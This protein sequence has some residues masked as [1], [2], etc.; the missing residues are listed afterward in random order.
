MNGGRR[1]HRGAVK[2]ILAWYLLAALAPPP[3]AADWEPA[4]LPLTGG[5]GTIAAFP[6]SA[7][8]IRRTL[9][10]AHAAHDAAR[11]RT[12]LDALARLGYAPSEETIRLL[13]PYLSARA[14]AGLARRFAANRAPIARSR[15][16]AEV[17]AGRRLI[18][19]IAFD[20]RSGRLFAGSV[21]GREL[22]VLDEGAW[23]AVPGVDGGSLFGMA[24]DA[25]RRLLWIASGSLDRTPHPETAFRGLIAVDLDDLRVRRRV[26]LAASPGDVTVG[27]DGAV[28]ASDGEG[29]AVF[30]LRPGEDSASL[31]VPA[32]RLRSA[33]GLAVAPDGR[34]L[35]VADYLFGIGIVDLASG[36]VRRLAARRPAM[37]DGIDGLLFHR[38]VLIAIQNGVAPHRIVRLRL[39]RAGGTVTAVDPLER[40]NPAWGEPTLGTIAGNELLYVADGQWERYAAGPIETG[41][42]RPTPIRAL[43]LPGTSVEPG[44]HRSRGARIG[45][46][47]EGQR[48]RRVERAGEGGAGGRLVLSAGPRG[49]GFASHRTT[50]LTGSGADHRVIRVRHECIMS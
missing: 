38:G 23:R 25:P 32:G 30:R 39:D 21:V 19:G 33:Q 31:L 37:L 7:S 41:A 8:A 3:G 46:G 13:F 2:A 22:L 4:R 5:P 45:T 29:G 44:L 12:G 36:H 49:Q 47:D 9:A 10:A 1:Q 34:R 28:Y 18:E 26:A 48:S 16:Y 27:G 14:Q 40:A 17:P 6:D 15:L 11:L 50:F 20:P 35:Y 42:P 43:A 24:V